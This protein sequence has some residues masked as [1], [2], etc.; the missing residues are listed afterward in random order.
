MKYKNEGEPKMKLKFG[1]R[2]HDVAK[3][4]DIDNLLSGVND[5]DLEY[6]QLVIP[7]ALKECDYSH[8]NILRIQNSLRQHRIK[9]AMLG[10]YFNPVH[11]NKEIV[12][13]GIEN[14]KRNIEIAKELGCKYVGSETGSY[15]GSPWTYVPKNHTQEGFMK[16]QKIFSELI[17]YAQKINVNVLFEP[18]W[19]HII[20]DVPMAKKFL[21]SFHMPNVFITIDLYNL[22]YEGNF[23]QRNEIFEK[24]LRTFKNQVK[25]IHLKDGKV[26]DGK[27]IQ[28]SPGQGQ[29]DY[30]FMLHCI[31]RYCPQAILIFE[32]VDRKNIAISLEK[33]KNIL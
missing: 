8:E 19:A 14:F 10:A 33:L 11:C 7:K 16:T 26:V 2:A 20:Y 31:E 3:K 9:V 21:D 13:S 6:I 28:L 30:P 25:I 12:M 22:L 18:A 5:L 27:K 32:G 15:N 1:V 29:F 4:T 23:E 24:A 17:K